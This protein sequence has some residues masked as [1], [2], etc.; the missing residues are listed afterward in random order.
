MIKFAGSS[1]AIVIGTLK[2]RY[3]RYGPLASSCRT[4]GTIG[5]GACLGGLSGLRHTRGRVA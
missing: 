5:S 3:C 2:T 1:D 4:A